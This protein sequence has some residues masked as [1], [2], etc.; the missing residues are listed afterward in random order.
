[1]FYVYILKSI[2]K[3]RLYIGLT[4]NVKRRFCEHN[5]GKV[6]ST[7]SYIPYEL[8][9]VENF[10]DKAKARRRELQI[11][12]SGLL[13]KKFKNMPPSS[14]PVQDAWFSSM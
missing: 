4:W 7:R 3:G 11:K 1:M 8:M 12:K 13:R 14:S 10:N 6:I 9:A 5:S 2:K